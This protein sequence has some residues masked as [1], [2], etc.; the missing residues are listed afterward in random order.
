LTILVNWTDPA[1]E[2]LDGVHEFIARD[3]Q[4]YANSFVQQIIDSVTRLEQFPLSGRVVPEAKQDHLR[5]VIFQGYRTIYWIVDEQR[6]DVLAVVHGSRDLT[7]P[8]NQP[9]ETN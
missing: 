6:I 9:W 8:I 4:F 1:L 3:S 7:N 2:D 5:E